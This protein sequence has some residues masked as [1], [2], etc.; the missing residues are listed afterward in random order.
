MDRLSS[1]CQDNIIIAWA[2]P[3]SLA[4]LGARLEAYAETK[5][6]ITTFRIAVR[7][8][9]V[10][11]CHNLPEEIISMISNKVRDIASKRKTKKW[12]TVT[13]CLTNTCDSLFHVSKEDLDMMDQFGDLP[14]EAEYEAAEA[15]QKDVIRYCKKLSNLEGSSKFAKCAQVRSRPSSSSNVML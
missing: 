14:D 11:A 15:H 1:T 7:N 2:T 9:A 13:K 8:S 6:A 3:V 12:T 10:T 4:Q 5:V